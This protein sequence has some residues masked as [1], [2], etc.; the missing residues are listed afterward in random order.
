M[1]AR[2]ITQF[3]LLAVT[4]LGVFVW[5]A[6]CE[7][8][9]PFGGVETL[10]AYT[11]EGNMLCSLGVSNLYVLAGVL[12]T[13]L[14]VR[15]AFCGYVC[16]IGT[17]S[18]YVRAV[19]RRLRIPEL[20]VAG[21]PDRGLSLLK[22]AVLAVVIVATWKAGELVFRAYDPCYALIGRHG[23]DITV[24]AYVVSGAI[25]VGSLFV[26]VP[27][28]RWFCPMAAVLALPARCG[29][30]RIE[31]D[32]QTCN[33]CGACDKAC[34]MAIPVH[35]LERVTDA[36]CT[37]CMRC[38]DA[39]P[40]KAK[41]ALRWSLPH[42]PDSTAPAPRRAGWIVAAVLAACIGG[43]V[44]ASYRFPVPSFVATVGRPSGETERLELSV[45][46]VSC[47]GRARLLVWFLERDDSYAVDGYLRVEAWPGPG[48]AKVVVRFDPSATDRDAIRRAVTEPYYQLADDFWRS[49]P[50]AIEGYDPLEMPSVEMP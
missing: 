29:L 39:C 8:W 32:G 50:F 27:F 19:A 1:N 37:Q 46:N 38:V 12:L 5:G 34:L 13:A 44:A 36:R 25:V 11:R 35:T 6:N 31:R 49:S 45:E 18:E 26:A 21:R 10:Y 7:R 22:Y 43:A 28:C 3:G 47:R 2:R 17:L 14:L 24:W 9:C 42:R 40:Q 30:A 4:L 41:G 15:R 20:R 16:P 23:T 33:E 48:R